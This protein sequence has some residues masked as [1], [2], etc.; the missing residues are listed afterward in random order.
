MLGPL[1]A[2]LKACPDTNRTRTTG[3]ASGHKPESMRSRI[4][5][6]RN[7]TIIQSLRRASEAPLVVAR[8]TVVVGA[9][10][11]HFHEPS[12][13]RIR[14]QDISPSS[15]F[16][17]LAWPGAGR[18]NHRPERRFLFGGKRR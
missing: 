1:A 10:I 14:P 9:F 3:E 17:Q 6:T 7:A 2:C 5:G 16:A 13:F 12:R 11:V 15:S 8:F 18:R 4:I